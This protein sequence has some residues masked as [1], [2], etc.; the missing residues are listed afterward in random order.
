MIKKL[1]FG[2]CIF[3][4]LLP[5]VF[6]ISVY[7]S[8]IVT[9]QLIVGEL[10]TFEVYE[11]LI[12]GT[13]DAT[14]HKVSF[15]E[16]S[17]SG[18]GD[19]DFR[20]GNVDR[21]GTIYLTN[22]DYINA[23][24]YNCDLFA[25]YAINGTLYSQPYLLDRDDNLVTDILYMSEID[26]RPFLN[27]IT[28]I[29]GQFTSQGSYDLGLDVSDQC[30]GLYCDRVTNDCATTCSDFSSNHHGMIYIMKI[31]TASNF[32][33]DSVDIVDSHR[34][35]SAEYVEAS[36]IFYFD[37]SESKAL[38]D[39]SVPISYGMDI[40]V[41]GNTEFISWG[42]SDQ[43]PSLIGITIVDMESNSIYNSE[44]QWLNGGTGYD[45]N[46]YSSGGFVIPGNAGSFASNG[47]LFVSLVTDT[48]KGEISVYSD[49]LT[50]IRSII[51]YEIASNSGNRKLSNFAVADINRDI[52]N[53]YCVMYNDTTRNNRN[54]INCFS[55]T[56]STLTNCSV[57]EWR[58]NNPITISLLEWDSI[59]MYLNLITPMGIYDLMEDNGGEC[60]LLY[61]FNNIDSG[62]DGV[63]LPVDVT[64]DGE[65]DLIYYGSDGA[66]LYST[67]DIAGQ[68]GT[69]TG[70][71]G[72]G[73]DF[74]MICE[75]FNYDFPIYNK[76]WEYYVNIELNES[77]APINDQLLFGNS[78]TWVIKDIPSSNVSYP[79]NS[80]ETII[81]T[82]T[83]PIVSHE[84][85]INGSYTNKTAELSYIIYDNLNR[86]SVAVA[87]YNH[88][89]WA[90]NKSKAD[91]SLIVP[92]G[93]E[94]EGE[95]FTGAWESIAYYG[96]ITN[97]QSMIPIKII[98]LIGQDTYSEYV[99]EK[100]ESLPFN[101]SREKSVYSVYIGGT[102]Y[103]N[104]MPY[105]NNKSFNVNT[106][107]I[108]KPFRFP[109]YGNQFGIDDIYI[110]RGTSKSV[111]TE[112]HFYEE[113]YIEPIID[114]DG[115]F[116]EEEKDKDWYSQLGEGF[117]DIGIVSKGSKLFFAILIMIM[118]AV[119]V[120]KGFGTVGIDGT[121]AG[122]IVGI[123]LMFEMFFFVY[124]GFIPIW[125]LFILLLLSAG[126]GFFIF[127]GKSSG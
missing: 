22:D 110:Y 62:S 78:H 19:N 70:T 18:S 79:I 111:N 32:Q 124:L 53:D 46:F 120:T 34:I 2:L 51:N 108:E 13:P 118:T 71:A 89:L 67:G 49:Q 23:F 75:E 115:G 47:E 85:N 4:L 86:P 81:Q 94:I 16:C 10:S 72:C 31:S 39:S 60:S 100:G 80:Q 69:V 15:S 88:T 1:I 103:L 107:Y 37:G 30:F 6:S 82:K 7:Y 64:D 29:D 73:H 26:S 116:T 102:E 104:N 63:L 101:V 28:F 14:A 27:S 65:P 35:D 59:S 50:E 54:W 25:S 61:D 83:Y 113:I 12:L 119:L 109:I 74:I 11:N 117:D 38:F 93:G 44:D 57:S 112:K 96:N 99:K 52:K 43:N 98:Q 121:M 97:N 20:Y 92:V 58:E 8:P 40:D 9:G 95:T 90:F 45:G 76:G 17:F 48:D 68:T 126:V 3:L 21:D 24:D 125:I 77:Y 42:S 123:L 122:I 41:D 106:L 91:Y 84:F 87:F 36:N 105:A 127:S 56:G 55:G 5:A 33:I 66:Y 114:D